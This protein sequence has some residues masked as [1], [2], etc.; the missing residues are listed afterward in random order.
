MVEQPGIGALP[1]EALVSGLRE[2]S[3]GSHLLEYAYDGL[4]GHRMLKQHSVLVL[5]YLDYGICARSHQCGVVPYSNSRTLFHGTTYVAAHA[6]LEKDLVFHALLD[7]A[8]KL[9]GLLSAAELSRIYELLVLTHP[10]VVGCNEATY[11]LLA[12]EPFHPEIGETTAELGDRLPPRG[13]L[14]VFQHCRAQ[15]ELPCAPVE[16]SSTMGCVLHAVR[17]NERADI[18]IEVGSEQLGKRD[19][20]LGGAAQTGNRE[21][22]IAGTTGAAVLLSM[23]QARSR[24][25]YPFQLGYAHREHIAIA[26]RALMRAGGMLWIVH[27]E[28]A[29]FRAIPAV[30]AILRGIGVVLP[31][32]DCDEVVSA[33]EERVVEGSEVA[34]SHM[35]VLGRDAS[36]RSLPAVAAVDDR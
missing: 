6:D 17:E 36:P 16:K 35:F 9:F 10:G 4:F 28:Q 24:L 29:A 5:D 2:G 27:F 15:A 14:E 12:A 23:G 25:R 7:G 19:L 3:V 18:L 8:Q 34:C 26:F 11:E 32:I 31:G 1:D 30:D 33:S 20:G 22:L 21:P 13:A